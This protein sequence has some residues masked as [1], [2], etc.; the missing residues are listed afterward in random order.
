[1]VASKG[2][3]GQPS[4]LQCLPSLREGSLRCSRSWPCRRTRCVRC[5]HY[6]QTDGDKSE[7][8]ARW[9]A[10]ATSAA[11]LGCAQARCRLPARAFAETARHS[12]GA[13][14]AN[15]SGGTRG[16]RYPAGATSVATRSAGLGSARASALRELTRRRLSERS[17]RSERSEFGGATPGR[18]SQCSRHAVPTPCRVP[19]AA[20]LGPPIGVEHS[21]MPWRCSLALTPTLSQREREQVSADLCASAVKALEVSS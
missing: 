21:S 19:P 17:E 14:H 5:A 6:A 20:T 16:G 12:P 1:M 11:L 13:P 8:E 10:R 7:D 18:A 15:R 9:R 3:G 2:A 4:A